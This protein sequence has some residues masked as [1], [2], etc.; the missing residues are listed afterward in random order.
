M[1]PTPVNPSRLFLASRIALIVTAMTFALRGNA[2][3]AWGTQ[4]A[5]TNEQ[6]GVISGTAFWGFTLAMLFGGPLCDA[7]GL[8]R[9][10]GVAFVG[11][12]AGIVLTMCAWNYMSLFIGTLIIGIANGSVEAACNPLIATMYSHDKTTYLNRFHVWFPGGIVVGGVAGYFADQIG[13]GWRAEFGLMLIP[14]V[15]Y[16]IMFLGQSFPATERVQSG[17]ST[18]GMFAACFNPIFILMV[19]CMLMTAA[20]E[21]GT[22]QWIPTILASAGVSGILVL[23]WINGLM[24]LG[25]QCAGPFVHKFSPLGMLLGSAVISGLGLLAIS[26]SHGYALFASATVF[27]MGACFFWPT[28]LGYVNTRFPSTGAVGLAIMG[29][30]GMLSAGLILPIIGHSY[31]RGIAIRVPV[32]QTIDTL[33]AAPATS[34]LATLWTDIQA[35]AGLHTLG[36]MALFPAVLT[37][38]FFLLFITSRKRVG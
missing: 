33:S 2:M 28:M 20:T 38:V 26:H 19:I 22:E 13:M 29:G 31:D 34:P 11:H 9:I 21:L 27:A 16:G 32:G 4:F 23:A 15:I 14:L 30:A 36:H 17:V 6:L 8:G 10:M 24:A 12:L 5:L 3:A 35:E 25:R 37:V 18:G 1:A 7:I